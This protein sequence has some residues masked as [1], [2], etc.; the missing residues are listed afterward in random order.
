MFPELWTA[1]RCLVDPR[2]MW[3]PD[4]CAHEEDPARLGSFLGWR[5]E[6]GPHGKVLE[7]AAL[8]YSKVA[9]SVRLGLF[10]GSGCS[11]IRLSPSHLKLFLRCVD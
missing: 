1:S 7:V 11:C 5:R 8:L 6:A 3:S 2:N 4:T 9:F 10:V